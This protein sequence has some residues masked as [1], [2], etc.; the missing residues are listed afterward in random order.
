MRYSKKEIVRHLFYIFSITVFLCVNAGYSQTNTLG[1]WNDHIPHSTIYDFV[2]VGSRVYSA[3]DLGLFVYDDAEK[4]IE[5]YSKLHGLSDIGIR[6][7]D[8]DSKRGVI[9]MGYLNGNLDLFDGENIRNVND[10]FRSTKYTGKKRIN[11]INV[12]GDVAYLSTGFGI[13]ELDLQ[14][15]IILNTLIIGENASELEVYDVAIDQN[16]NE[17]YAATESGLLKANLDDPLIFYPSWKKITDLPQGA[18]TDVEVFNEYVFTNWNT[19]NPDD[20]IYYYDG[21]SWRKYI[22]VPNASKTDIRVNNGYMGI[23]STFGT[24]IINPDLSVRYYLSEAFLPGNYTPFVV[25]PDNERTF[26]VGNIKNGLVRFDDRSFAIERHVPD[27]P[28]SSEGYR[29]TAEN[30]VLYVSTGAIDGVWSSLYL[31]EGIFMYK[32]FEWINT[33]SSDLKNIRDIVQITVHPSNPDKLFASAWGTGIVEITNGEVDTIWDHISTNNALSGAVG[34]SESDIRTGGL[35]FD[36]PG[37]MWATNSK[38]EQPLVVRRKNG[39]WESYS[40]GS[41]GNSSNDFKDIKINELNQIWMQTRSNGIVV[42]RLNNGVPI[43]F[44]GVQSGEGKGNLPSNGV[45]SFAE[46]QDGEMWIGTDAGLVVLYSPQNIFASGSYDAQPVLF[47]ED[48]VVQRLLGAEEVTAIAIDGANKKW[49]GTQNSGVFYCSKDGTETIYHFTKESSPLLSNTILD[50][51]IDHLSGEVFFL[52]S[53]GVVSFRGSATA[54][55]DNYNNVYT[56]PN[57]VRPD[58]EGPIFIRGLVTNAQVKITDVAGNI[59]YEM[60]A[61]GG[62]AVWYGRDL[63]GDKVATGVYV[64][65]ITND[66]GSL[67]ATTKILIVN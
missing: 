51:A 22:D 20:S 43:A 7:M 56:Y 5:T 55:N 52:T 62:Q 46:D 4:T 26:W 63:N 37:N 49:F 36:E 34:S 64:A 35:V 1:I 65:H 45:L 25:W 32:D 19:G 33:P 41:F 44:N 16:R 13:V 10:I 6:A 9:L 38:T 21:N 18:Y 53:E 30:N 8:Y 59:V 54:G 47:E 60:V 15:L 40:L 28:Y 57:P 24:S 66:D 3:T 12:Q 14:N 11:H 42:A 61:E 31:Q 29:V 17:I 27:G 50:I 48:G 67:T 58:H 2:K 23:A 39:L